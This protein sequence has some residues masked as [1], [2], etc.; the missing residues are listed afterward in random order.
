[1]T[2]VDD[3]TP[4]EPGFRWV[5]VRD[6]RLTGRVR[7]EQIPADAPDPETVVDS[8]EQVAHVR[9]LVERL[10]NGTF[11]HHPQPIPPGERR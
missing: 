7:R 4:C 1:M 9:L 6:D 3:E 11:H 8:P 2:G 5:E 10:L